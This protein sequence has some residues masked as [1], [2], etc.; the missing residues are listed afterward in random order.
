ML[1]GEPIPIEVGAGVQPYA[2][3]RVRRG[4]TVAEVSATGARARFGRT[5]ELGRTARVVRS[6]Q[7]TVLPIVRNLA[8]FSGAVIVMLLAYAYWLGLP[9]GR[10]HSAHFD[11]GPCIDSRSAA[12]DV[13]ARI[14]AGR[15]CA[16][17]KGRPADAPVRGQ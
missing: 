15:P 8:C 10:H 11:R 4:E 16:G 5:A 13:H 1:T 14:R 17:T 7:K 12:G 6:R 9:L 2:G 3:A